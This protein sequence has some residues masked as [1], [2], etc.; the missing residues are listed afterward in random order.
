[1]KSLFQIAESLSTKIDTITA[2]I[3][4]AVKQLCNCDVVI[5]PNTQSLVCDAGGDKTTVIFYANTPDS[6]T[7]DGITTW[8]RNTD[9][10][11]VSGT[12]LLINT[13]CPVEI[14]IRDNTR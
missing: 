4:D 3:T 9:D 5:V 6:S 2:T 7:L 11:D 12:K 10:I 13:D 14:E 1:M 8:T